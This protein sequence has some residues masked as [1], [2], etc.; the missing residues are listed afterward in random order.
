MTDTPPPGAPDGARVHGDASA[1]A[2]VTVTKLDVPRP[3]TPAQADAVFEPQAADV[4]PLDSVVVD[5][6]VLKPSLTALV[7]WAATLLAAAL[8]QHGLLSQG[9]ADQLAPIL[10]GL[11]LAGGTLAWSIAQKHLA[12]GRIRRAALA[13]PAKVVL[14]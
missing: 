13:P 3:L 4:L 12:A 10:G 8:V 11:A 9:S 1:L 2:A 6:S 14:R 5:A 7:R